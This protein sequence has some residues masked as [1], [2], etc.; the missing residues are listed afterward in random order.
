M[1]KKEIFKLLTGTDTPPK[2]LLWYRTDDCII[3]LSTPNKF[4]ICTAPEAIF[5][6]QPVIPE[7]FKWGK[8]PQKFPWKV[9]ESNSLKFWEWRHVKKIYKILVHSSLL[10]PLLRK[11][12]EMLFHSPI[13]ISVNINRNFMSNGKRPRYFFIPNRFTYY[14][15]QSRIKLPQQ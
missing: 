9:S 8:L 13:R 1:Q 7:L 14:T 10:C 12:W 2:A 15:K 3:P 11:L 4:S 5:S 6:I